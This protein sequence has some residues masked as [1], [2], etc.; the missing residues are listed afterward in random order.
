[1]EIV[2]NGD[3]NAEREKAKF[4]LVSCAGGVQQCEGRRSLGRGMMM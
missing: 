2:E 4:V 1:M 3:V